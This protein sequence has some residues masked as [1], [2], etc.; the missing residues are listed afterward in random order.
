MDAV[1]AGVKAPHDAGSHRR[2]TEERDD[3]WLAPGAARV[4]GAGIRTRPE[5]PDPLRTAFQRD[6][7][8][9]IHSTAFRRLKHK[10]QV[11]IAPDG[12]HYRTRLTHTLEVAQVARTI[13]RALRRNEDLAE[14]IAL[15]HDLGHTP[16]GHLGEDVLRDVLGVPFHHA[17]QSVRVV[18]VLER[19]PHGLNLT[20]EVRDGI[21]H[22]SWNRSLPATHE[23]FAVRYAD[24]IAYL[25]HDV[26]DAIRAGLLRESDLPSAVGRAL[27]SGSSARITA[28]VSDVVE[29]SDV[30]SAPGLCPG[31]R[32]SRSVFDV[33]D[34]FR[35]FMFETVY[36]GPA[37][38]ADMSA[39][40][41]VLEF[42]ITHY[43]DHDAGEA[44]GLPEAAGVVGDPREQR[45]VDHVASMTDRF[46]IGA[47]ERLSGRTVDLT[48]V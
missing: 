21:S 5:A 45:L 20:A 32:M 46:A 33:M 14:A 48:S 38:A 10:T 24:R 43:L 39:A 18:E 30:T 37:V 15:G 2:A 27:G 42:L 8:R 1:A 6:R 35:T 47:Y 23:A 16:F 22:S 41:R 17:E 44:G 28:L 19:R 12:D 7:D 29:A 9:I 13:A 36:L 25:N 11:F 3:M 31:V 34:E 40:R 4:Q 26:D